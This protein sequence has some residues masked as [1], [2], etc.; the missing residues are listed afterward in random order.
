MS[1]RAK[2]GGKNTLKPGASTT[3]P[4]AKTA[5]RKA[6]PEDRDVDAVEF[7]AIDWEKIEPETVE[8][9]PALVEHIRARGKLTPLTLRVGAEQ[10]AEARRLAESTGSK[11]QKVLRQWLAE[12]ASRARAKRLRSYKRAAPEAG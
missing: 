1:R 8:L 7:D 12:G 4:R 2:A 6:R 3:R 10:V 9:D 11:Y 5:S